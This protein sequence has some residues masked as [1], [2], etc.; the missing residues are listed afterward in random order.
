MTTTAAAPSTAATAECAAPGGRRRVA[1]IGGGR[2][3]EH[4]VSLATA[5]SVRTALDPARYEPVAL[6]IGTDGLWYL[7]DG[8][9]DTDP[10]AGTQAGGSDGAGPG[11]ALGTTPAASLAAALTVLDGCDLAFPA[12][13]GPLGEDGTLAGLLE[14]AG[15]PYVGAGVR[16]GALAM[17]KWATKLV[18]TECGLS[19]APGRL[20]TAAT[21][22]RLRF[23]GPV[24]VKP[25][26]AGSSH[27]VA[28]VEHAA[29]LAP[30]VAAALALD[31]RVL[32]EEVVR[33][34]EVDIAVLE[35][36]DGSLFVSPSL[37]IA[38]PDGS[39]FDTRL[40]YGGTAEFHIPADL[41]DAVRRRL[42]E[43][44]RTL[45]ASLGCSGVARFDFFVTDGLT[46]RLADGGLV[47]NEVNTMPGM[48][49]QS[50][51]PKMFA[52]AGLP[53][54][55]LLDQLVRTSLARR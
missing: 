38:V 19:V 53:Y 25:V 30:A 54:A 22:G 49:A 50:Q 33:G 15:V 2:S 12:V 8:E 10:D 45:F 20:V 44:A 35:R 36:E 3:C 4:E 24:V 55:E 31:D 28:L 7:L 13:H 39:L 23:R 41:D 47:L 16:G 21:A 27:G 32:V 11:R 9:L 43:A 26:A 46:D 17:D 52:A 18:A 34:R 42:A 1:V 5:A 29:D 40:K 51:V 48:T 6:T 37:E 14:L